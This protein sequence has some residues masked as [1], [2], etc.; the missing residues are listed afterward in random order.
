MSMQF[1]VVPRPSTHRSRPATCRVPSPSRSASSESPPGNWPHRLRHR[2]RWHHL[3][4]NP[5]RHRNRRRTCHRRC[6]RCPPLR[7]RPVLTPSISWPPIEPPDEPPDEPPEDPP[8][9]PP[10]D[11]PDMPP[12]EPP[13]MP[14]DEPPDMPPAYHRQTCHRRRSRRLTCRHRMNRR[15]T[16]PPPEDATGM[17]PPEL[18]PDHWTQLEQPAI[19]SPAQ[20]TTTQCAALQRV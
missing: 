16:I 9:E 14:P 5:C 11:P 13:D 6:I 15:Q 20:A 7:R 19:R 1:R 4:R 3:L 12:W 10:E 17:T 8:D 2:R 18:P